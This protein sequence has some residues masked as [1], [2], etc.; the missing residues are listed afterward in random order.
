MNH[1]S[2]LGQS[3]LKV[4]RMG[5][6][7]RVWGQPKGLARWT[8]AQ[9]AYAPSHGASEEEQAQDAGVRAEVWQLLERLTAGGGS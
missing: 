7:A 5:V 2:L 9:L 6:G 1:K 4:P 8:P 3:N